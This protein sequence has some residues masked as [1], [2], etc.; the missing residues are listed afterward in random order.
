MTNQV[1]TIGVVLFQATNPLTK[2]YKRDLCFIG[3]I[4]IKRHSL[5]GKGP[6]C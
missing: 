3:Q 1:Q 6:Y 4:F 2:N 5:F